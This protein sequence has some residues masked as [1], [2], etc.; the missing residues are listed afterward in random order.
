MAY[1]SDDITK[2]IGA[3]IVY[4]GPLGLNFSFLENRCD[5]IIDLSADSF[6]I[7]MTA[8]ALLSHASI[9]YLDSDFSMPYPLN[10]IPVITDSATSSFLL[11]KGA[12][13]IRQYQK[14]MWLRKG[15]N[16]WAKHIEDVFKPVFDKLNKKMT[17]DYENY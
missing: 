12:S 11:K 14:S 1:F 7:D 5:L 8:Q 3:A 17:L 13:L 16:L 15:F 9:A 6:V 10:Y 2:P 4:R